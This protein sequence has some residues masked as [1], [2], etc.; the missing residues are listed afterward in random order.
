MAQIKSNQVS[1]SWKNAI[2]GMSPASLGV[3]KKFTPP[4]APTNPTSFSG[5]AAAGVKS[6]YNAWANTQA[7]NSSNFKSPLTVSGNTSRGG[8]VNPGMSALTGTLPSRLPTTQDLQQ[9]AQTAIG[10]KGQVG[11]SN[12]LNL[13]LPQ[14]GSIGLSNLRNQSSQNGMTG[15]GV[16][17]TATSNQ[18]NPATTPSREQ[19]IAALTGQM[20]GLQSQLDA[21]RAAERAQASGG[22][23]T[24]TQNDPFAGV[25]NDLRNVSTSNEE[26]NRV[27]KEMEEVARGNRA[28]ADNAARISEQYGAEIN[29]VGQL[30]AGAVA[31]NLST[32]S[33][34]VGSGNAAIASQ[35]ASSRMA[36]LAQGQAAALKGTEQ[37][38]TAQEQTLQGLDPSLQASL[39]QQ[40]TGVTGLSNAGNLAQPVQV[41]YSNQFINPT[42]GQSAG[43]AGLGG[44]AGY[45]AAQQ[46]IELAGQYPDAG[47]QYDA[48][49]SPEQ[50]L[51]RIQQAIQG[52]PTYQRGAFGTAGASS[53]I[54]AQQLGAAGTL[55]QQ[56][57]QLQTV[58]N[59]ADANFNL[60]LDIAKRGQINDLNQPVLNQLAQGISRGLTSDQDVVA[61][62]SGLQTVRSQYAAIL[63]GGTPTDATQAMAA[64]KIPDTVSLGALQEVERTMKSLISNTVSS[65]NQQI[66]AYSNQ[67]GSGGG[68]SFAEQW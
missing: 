68:N 14:Y 38:L 37:Q 66:G 64:E 11:S 2:Q 48:N 57:S 21:K 52:S 58:G 41:P 40:Q 33:N 31:G 22:A 9:Q 63:G 34:V 7:M 60:I 44:Y 6:G 28:I 49:L 35:S 12:S 51:Q 24:G 3:P 45:N 53:Y 65:Y 27:R 13:N 50:N 10:G 47:V 61:F 29:R 19:Q 67:G 18:T 8:T 54:G 5:P 59:A 26:Q 15:S 25:L 4:K 39:T 1:Q 30:G 16:V 43:G 62:R 55:T 56:V 32:G 46:A 17:N 23:T 36:A 20:T 42:T